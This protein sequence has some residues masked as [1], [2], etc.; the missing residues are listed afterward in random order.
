MVKVTKMKR[1]ILLCVIL[2]A[3]LPL[4]PKVAATAHVSVELNR[5][6]VFVQQPFHVTITVYTTTWFTAPPQFG[7]LQIP[8]AFI[9]PFDQTQPG[10]FTI[11]GKQY[12]GVQ[13][14][15]IVFPYSTGSY[16]VPPIEVT[17]QSPPEGSSTARQQILKTDPKP[18]T[19]NDIP[20]SL[21]KMGAWFVARS[22]T[23]HEQWNPALDAPKVGDVIRRTLTIDALGTLPQFI[24]NL[25][26]QEKVDWASTYPQE[27]VLTDTRAGGDANGRSVQ[28]ITYLLEKAGD[29][30]LPG[31]TL[32]YWNPYT[33][34]I[35]THTIDARKVY[36]ADNP[37][38]GILTTLKDSLNATV[39][40]S[41]A[42]PHEKK[43]FTILGMS[44]YAFAGLVI[45]A[46]CVLW[47][48]VK[49]A[50]RLR[51]AYRTRREKYV[52]SEQYLFDVFRKSNGNA[53]TFLHT[54]Y[55]WWDSFAGRPS[56]SVSASFAGKPGEAAAFSRF[57]DRFLH[58]QATGDSSSVKASLEQLRKDIEAEETGKDD[59]FP[60]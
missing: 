33:A 37:N 6:T 14:Y 21:K 39:S 44:W 24:P 13:F 41:V 49:F 52:H 57:F 55:V 11:G 4:A 34:R 56:A 59:Y 7:N 26:G 53:Y 48:L 32:S 46:G 42:A 47:L 60:L 20:A 19:V 35:E 12:P 50:I 1:N 30:T 27:P 25:T 38:L 40:P 3:L 17:V 18:F 2:C 16:T 5:S 36:V 43:A 28:T 22:A 58:N 15:Y 51:H 10:M 29:F 8:N 54:L 9:V 23:L 45:V 31:I